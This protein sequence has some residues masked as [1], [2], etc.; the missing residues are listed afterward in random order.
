MRTWNYITHFIN[1]EHIFFFN[2]LQPVEENNWQDQFHL[3]SQAIALFKMRTDFARVTEDKNRNKNRRHSCSPVTRKYY[4]MNDW[5]AEDS[6]LLFHHSGWFLQFFFFTQ[7]YLWSCFVWS[8]I[9][10]RPDR[11]RIIRSS[12]CCLRTYRRSIDRHISG[13]NRNR[14]DYRL[15]WLCRNGCRCGRRKSLSF[16]CGTSL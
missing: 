9:R 4:L 14:F 12:S 3:N 6:P 13:G 11:R 10:S 5:R 8:S 2:R 1:A 16:C 15:I 7:F